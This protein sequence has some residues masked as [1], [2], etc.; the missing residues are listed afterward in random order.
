MLT[1]LIHF[2]SVR[3][4]P[5]AMFWQSLTWREIVSLAEKCLGISH[6]LGVKEDP[7][8]TG[9][10]KGTAE[11]PCDHAGTSP[12]ATR[13]PVQRDMP[14]V[15][16]RKRPHG[17]RSLGSWDHYRVCIWICGLGS[18][19]ICEGHIG[20]TGDQRVLGRQFYSC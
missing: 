10:G 8:H 5:S 9:G 7:A 17:G 18:D 6:S 13:T 1:A 4:S 11:S 16:E 12:P 20:G 19:M 14:T 15:G 2:H 3:G